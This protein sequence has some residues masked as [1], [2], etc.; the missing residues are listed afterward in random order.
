MK[1][2][3]KHHTIGFATIEA[4]DWH[5]RNLFADGWQTQVELTPKAHRALHSAKATIKRERRPRYLEASRQLP[6]RQYRSL[7]SKARVLP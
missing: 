6:Y 4:I 3:H 1:R 2:M 7:F 5:L